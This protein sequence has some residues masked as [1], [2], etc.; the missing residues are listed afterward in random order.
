M[1]SNK[2]N[3]LTDYQKDLIEK[4]KNRLFQKTH[5]LFQ[6]YNTPIYDLMA[7]PLKISSLY[8]SLIILS[9]LLLRYFKLLKFIIRLDKL[10]LQI[11][12]LAIIFVFIYLH[13]Y[14]L[15]QNIIYMAKTSEDNLTLYKY[16]KAKT[17]SE[18]MLSLFLSIFISNMLS[19]IVSFNLKKPSKYYEQIM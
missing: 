7:S 5:W 11:I 1:D 15:N 12:I 3:T 10:K 6:N 18:T 16:E 9:A 2:K 14:K 4:G 13:Q 19:S 17:G 8:C